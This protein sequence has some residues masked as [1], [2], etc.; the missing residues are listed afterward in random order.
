MVSWLLSDDVVIAVSSGAGTIALNVRIGS[1]SDD[2]EERSTGKVSLT[3]SD[4]EMVNDQGGLQTIGLRFNNI[5]IPQGATINSAS[6]QF[7]VDETNSGTTSL[8]IRGEAKDNAATFANGNG[9]ITSRPATV[10]TVPWSPVPWTV[11]GAAGPDQQTPDLA[12]IIQEVV[13][14]SGWASG[15]SLVIIISGTGERTAESYNG[16]PSGA[17]ML[18]VVYTP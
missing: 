12:T 8:S 2:A 11:V 17:S 14:R 9:N 18:S 1:S 4:L 10:A 7:Q 13:N 16:Q 15:N 6:V 3:S 5:T